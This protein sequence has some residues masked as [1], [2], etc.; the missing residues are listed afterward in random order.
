M[1]S[2]LLSKL[3]EARRY[4]KYSKVWLWC[5]A[6][7]LENACYNKKII[8]DVGGIEAV[9]EA[10]KKHFDVPKVQ[11]YGHAALRR[12]KIKKPKI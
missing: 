11:K 1:A 10:M 3:E 12:L 9:V 6:E 4:G 2:S 5:S 8:V 7:A